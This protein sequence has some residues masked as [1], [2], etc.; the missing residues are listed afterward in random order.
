LGG[1]PAAA[2]LIRC[3]SEVGRYGTGLPETIHEGIFEV[4]L[5]D[6]LLGRSGASLFGLD[7]SS[8]SIKL[9]QLGRDSGGQYVLERLASEPLGKGL[10]VDG[11]VEKFDEVVE[12]VRR[13]VARSGTRERQVALAMPAASV[14]TK[15]IV[16]PAGLREDEMEQQ[17][18][19]EANQYIPFSL[20]EVALDFCVIGPS[21]GSEEEV[22]VMIAASRKDRVQDR[23][24]LVEAA[25][26]VPVVLDVE[27]HASRLAM[28]RVLT[29]RPELEA[30][31][32]VAM[33]EIGA[34]ATSLKVLQDDDLLYD[35]DQAFGGAQLT[36]LIARSYGLTV[37]EAEIKKVQGGLPD[38]YTS[39]LL[40]PFVDSLAQ[41]ISRSLQYFFT[42][43]PHHKVDEVA[44]AGGTALLPGLS[45]RV[46]EFSGFRT[47]VVDPFEGMKISPSIGQE[48]LAREAPSY[49][50]ACG[51]AMRRFLK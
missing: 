28:Q 14:I 34:D 13:I 3:A 27:S 22:D 12:A 4:S 49:L 21:R 35:R 9:V 29:Q 48:R 20:E 16:L 39:Q 47:R 36:Q 23:Q 15:K 51:L 8:S 25:G 26:L 37:D 43:T 6:R 17:V 19:S 42:S 45:E 31:A 40:E 24:S 46:E 10:I 5:L 50:I 11:H 18:E 33:F 38:D 41:E 1:R 44:L 2:S 7:I 30:D 32:L